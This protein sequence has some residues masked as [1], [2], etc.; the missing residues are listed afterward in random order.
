MTVL[1]RC[2]QAGILDPTWRLPLGAD[3]GRDNI[4]KDTAVAVA[5]EEP[6]ARKEWGALLA[7]F[8]RS[9]QEAQ[10]LY[11]REPG[12]KDA[13][14]VDNYIGIQVCECLLYQCTV[15]ILARALGYNWTFSISDPKGAFRIYAPKTWHLARDWFG[16][17]IGFPPFV[18]AS[19]T[20]QMSLFQS[21]LFFLSVIP[22]VATSKS[23][24]SDK[25]LLWLMFQAIPCNR[26]LL[27]CA[28]KL[29]VWRMSKQYGDLSG[30]MSIY[31]GIE[32]PFTLAA[33]GKG[34]V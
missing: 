28:R 16:R 33:K 31:Y 17:F 14:S 19:A 10:G 9:T 29:W 12:N 21:V 8:M 22:T 32:H 18:R 4:Q 2:R 34:F 5:L 26:L 30:L 11:R 23:N 15:N 3:G 13:Q 6:C 7:R 27:R 1:E 24:T 25:I 20:G